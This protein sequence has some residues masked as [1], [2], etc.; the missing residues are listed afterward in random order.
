[1]AKYFYRLMVYMVSGLLLI[2]CTGSGE[3]TG[4]GFDTVSVGAIS[5]LD[6]SSVRVNGTNFR[7][8]DATIKVDDNPSPS[9]L[10][11]GMVVVVSG[12]TD[13]NGVSTANSV[14]A[15]S[16]VRGE[17]TAVDPLVIMGFTINLTELTR[18]DAGVNTGIGDF[19]AV[20]GFLSGDQS[21]NA[22][23]IDNSNKAAG[24]KL[25]GLVSGLDGKT[26]NIGTQAVDFSG[27]SD[28]ELS[29]HFP[30]GIQN[31]M[32]VEVFGSLNVD[33]LVATKVE[34]HGE[35]IV[36]VAKAHI[37]GHIL[38][39]QTDGFTLTNGQVVVTDNQTLF[40]NGVQADLAAGMEIEVE[41]PI[42]GGVLKASKVKLKGNIKLQSYVETINNN[43]ATS[44][45][46]TLAGMET[47]NVSVDSNADIRL[48]L[49][50]LARGQNVFVRGIR[51]G[52]TI[53]ALRI[54]D[55]SDKTDVILQGP[56]TA[57]ENPVA[58]IM[59]IGVDVSTILQPTN[60]LNSAGQTG[61]ANFFSG[62]VLGELIK[63]QGD[64][65]TS[66]QGESTVYSI[67]WRS[68]EPELP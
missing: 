65:V 23:R 40:R 36:N 47:L 19:V 58:S 38:S 64:V 7:T 27:V 25:T 63:A 16:V 45:S 29:N 41:G 59:G 55:Q 37:Q 43:T 10:Q 52:D 61:L 2:A 31:N 8:V 39:L 60:I 15:K 12:S 3:E 42:T 34:L 26:F 9:D 66:V 46:F 32:I 4:T 68:I 62:T 30:G 11:E 22:T 20:S 48:D 28:A 51:Q 5:S 6:A 35:E 14:I 67:E 50:A 56:I 54:E 44:A 17:I 21:I 18:V 33:T 53:K 57:L 49:T 1:M 13:D 24:V